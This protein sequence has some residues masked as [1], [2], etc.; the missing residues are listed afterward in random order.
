MPW[1]EYYQV[2]IATGMKAVFSHR[3][4]LALYE[5]TDLIPTEFHVT[6][7]RPSR[8]SL[9]NVRYHTA[10]LRAGE[11]A[12]R[13]GLPLTDV[14]R[15]L[16]DLYRWGESPEWIAQATLQALERGLLSEDRLMER[17]E[18]YSKTFRKLI[19]NILKKGRVEIQ[20]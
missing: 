20:Q 9:E 4:A 14:P 12:T 8:K 17:I 15:T 11:I 5:L 10:A 6:V 1:S 13:H 16:Y 2:W 3:S 7:S 18:I 19:Q